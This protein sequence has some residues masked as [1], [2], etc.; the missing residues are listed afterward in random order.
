M[1]ALIDTVN[2]RKRETDTRSVYR[3]QLLRIGHAYTHCKGRVFFFF[4][5]IVDFL[6]ERW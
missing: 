2:P 1:A 3:T 4:F 6:R 5:E